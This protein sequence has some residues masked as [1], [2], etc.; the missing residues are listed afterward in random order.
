MTTQIAVKLP[1]RLVTEIDRLVADGSFASRSDAVRHGIESLV[2]SA[3]RHRIDRAFAE[4]FRR[5]PD[6]E[7]DVAE[8]TRLAVEAIND[9][10]WERWW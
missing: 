7:A 5:H 8:A 4:G 10:P 2:R 3:E 6:T 9:E 1:D